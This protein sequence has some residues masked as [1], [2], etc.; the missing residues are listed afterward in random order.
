MTGD[1]PDGVDE[2]EEYPMRK[3]VG[4]LVSLAGIVVIVLFF[5]S[6]RTGTV[7]LAESFGFADKQL[8]GVL[9]GLLAIVIGVGIAL[10]GY[11]IE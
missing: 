10:S 4:G 9:L 2:V 1:L 3:R 7:P 11:V 5:D 6:G 8:E